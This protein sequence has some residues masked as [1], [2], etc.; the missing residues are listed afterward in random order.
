MVEHSQATNAAETD[1]SMISTDQPVTTSERSLTKGTPGVD[2]SGL[3]SSSTPGP[4]LAADLER[5]ASK[6]LTWLDEVL[7][8]PIDEENAPLLRAQSSAAM[9]ALNTQIRADSLRLRAQRQDAALDRLLAQIAA[10]EGRI[11]KT[12][13]RPASTKSLGDCAAL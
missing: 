3:S 1:C 6:A 5:V 11:P 7:G 13:G 9:T 12:E 4:Q 2:I 8:K 10:Q